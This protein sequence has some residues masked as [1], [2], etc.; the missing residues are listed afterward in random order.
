MTKIVVFDSGLGSLSIIK[1]IQKIC[2]ADI[3]YYADQ[4][5]YPYGDKSHAQLDSIIKKTDRKSVV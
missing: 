2:K 4:K 1:P 3:A 5:N